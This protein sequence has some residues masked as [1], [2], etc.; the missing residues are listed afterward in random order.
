MPVPALK[1]ATRITTFN[2]DYSN[3]RL[4][5]YAERS[6]N[7]ELNVIQSGIILTKIDYI[8]ESEDL[9]VIEDEVNVLKGPCP[10]TVNDGTYPLSK[11]NWN[12]END[13]W[14]ARSYLIVLTV[15][16][17]VNDL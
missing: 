2:K 6:V 17:S 13:N 7:Y 1:A 12:Y 10:N 4:T 9:F 15:Q 5:F 3:N 8:G 11:K 14:Y 16:A